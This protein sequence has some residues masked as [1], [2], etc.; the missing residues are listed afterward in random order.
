MNKNI[1]RKVCIKYFVCN[2][3]KLEMYN[4][5]HGRFFSVWIDFDLQIRQDF[6]RIILVS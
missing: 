4:V 3:D 6:L 1:V 5:E 2:V